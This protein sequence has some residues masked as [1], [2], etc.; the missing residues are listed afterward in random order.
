MKTPI[1]IFLYFFIFLMFQCCSPNKE[2]EYLN[3]EQ[4]YSLTDTLKGEILSTPIKSG[5]GSVKLYYTKYGLLACTKLDNNI[6]QLLDSTDASML[7]ATGRRGRGPNE[8]LMTMPMQYDY[9]TDRFSV[10]DMYTQEMATYLISAD[11]IYLIN[12]INLKKDMQCVKYVTDSLLVFNNFYPNQKIGLMNT[13]AEIVYEEECNFL[14]DD[15]IKTINAYHGIKLEVSPDKAHTVAIDGSFATIK[16][17]LNQLYTLELQWKKT[18]F[19]PKY[20]FNPKKDW[21]IRDDDNWLGFSSIYLTNKYIYLRNNERQYIDFI[22]ETPNPK[23][24]YITVMDYNGNIIKKYLMDKF[25]VSFT[26]T[27]DDKYLY[28]TIYDP[29]FLVAKYSL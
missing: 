2:I 15:R 11:S 20:K 24:S 28:A 14:D 6:F 4:F 7:T 22:N 16:V 18:L 25:F 9:L 3:P 26:V 10:F 12:R 27:P 13:N 17:F 23:H 29:D 1:K 21:Y 8:F 5:A 19:K